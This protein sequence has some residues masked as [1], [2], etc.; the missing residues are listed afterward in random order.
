VPYHGAGAKGYKPNTKPLERRRN[1]LAVLKLTVPAYTIRYRRPA[2]NS[3]PKP[4]SESLAQLLQGDAVD[5]RRRREEDM[6]SNGLHGPRESGTCRPLEA[7]NVALVVGGRK[8]ETRC[9]YA[10]FAMT[11]GT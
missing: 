6:N 10:V 4:R 3:C 11:W 2:V 9:L 8:P 1:G 5:G 7:C